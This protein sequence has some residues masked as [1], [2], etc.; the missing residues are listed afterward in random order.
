MMA[1][2]GLRQL[3]QLQALHSEILTIFSDALG[4]PLQGLQQGARRVGLAT[5]TKRRVRELEATCGFIRHISAQKALA[6]AEEVKL[7]VLKAKQHKVDAQVH[8]EV[9]ATST[10]DKE[11]QKPAHEQSEKEGEVK[12]QEAPSMSAPHTNKGAGVD[13]LSKALQDHHA[14]PGLQADWKDRGLAESPMVPTYV[15]EAGAMSCEDHELA[16]VGDA[17]T[18][19]HEEVVLEG[20]EYHDCLDHGWAPPQCQDM[21]TKRAQPTFMTRVPRVMTRVPRVTNLVDFRACNPRV[22]QCEVSGG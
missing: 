11:L 2:D 7:E 20:E 17:S 16:E 9:S 6:F 21:R 10:A 5:K 15:S 12:A 4:E 3:G 8:A 1:I 19:N 22:T 14:A 13:D 18:K